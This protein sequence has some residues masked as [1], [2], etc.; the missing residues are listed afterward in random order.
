[1]S[2]AVG[3]RHGSDPVWLWCRPASATVFLPFAW[4]LAYAVGA[5]LKSQKNEVQ[6]T[7]MQAYRL[8]IRKAKRATLTKAIGAG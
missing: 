3:H 8:K 1:M 6:K 5:A 2:C 7:Q 4:E